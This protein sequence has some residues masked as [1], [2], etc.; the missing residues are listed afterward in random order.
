MLLYG[1]SWEKYNMG[2]ISRNGYKFIIA[3]LTITVFFGVGAL[4]IAAFKA[5]YAATGDVLQSVFAALLIETGAIDI[6][7]ALMVLKK[8]HLLY[9]TGAAIHFG[10][11]VAYNYVQVSTHVMAYSTWLEGRTVL[12]MALAVGPVVALLF[13]ALTLGSVVEAYSKYQSVEES[14]GIEF[15]REMEREKLRLEHEE[16]LMEIRERAKLERQKLREEKKEKGKKEEE[17]AGKEEKLSR[18]F[19][20]NGKVALP[21]IRNKKHFD[22]LVRSGEID[23]GKLT[24]KML[25]EAGVVKSVRNGNYWLSAHKSK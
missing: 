13:I 14:A 18:I 12:V 25:V 10:I 7:F 21:Q 22:E 11:S 2:N 17:K 5:F 16:R 3:A 9:L 4:I 8:N 15:Q 23:V 24:A 1:R 6:A 20:E 19:P